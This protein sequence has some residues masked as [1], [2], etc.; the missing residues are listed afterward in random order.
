MS[1]KVTGEDVLLFLT[2][3]EIQGIRVGMTIDEVKEKLGQPREVIGDSNVGYLMY[4]IFRIGYRGNII[5][6]MALFF[7]KYPDVSICLD[8]KDDEEHFEIS[9]GTKINEMIRLM[10]YK[11]IRWDCYDKSNSDYF[12]VR[13]EIKV[14]LIFDLYDGSL[15]MISYLQ[16]A[17]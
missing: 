11:G 13:S 10:N 5:D 14:A 12:T 2:T 6:E 4:G 15:F 8:Y 7:Y 1:I 3:G 16:D 17:I 9:A